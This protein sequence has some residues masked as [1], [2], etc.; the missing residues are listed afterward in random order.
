MKLIRIVIPKNT[1]INEEVSGVF[2]IEVSFD[3]SIPIDWED[4]TNLTNIHFYKDAINE[5]YDYLTYYIILNEYVLTLNWSVLTDANK[6]III[7]EYASPTNLEEQKTFL[8]TNGY[9]NND[10]DEYL[11]D[12]WYAFYIKLLVECNT[13]VGYFIKSLYFYYQKADAEAILSSIS[14]LIIKY[15]TKG[16]IGLNLLGNTTENSLIDFIESKND[17]YENGLNELPYQIKQTVTKSHI[18]SHLKTILFEG[19]FERD[20]DEDGL[21]YH[22]DVRSL[23]SAIDSGQTNQSTDAGI[24][25]FYAYDSIGGQAITKDSEINCNI[26]RD[27]LFNDGDVF[28]KIS[29]VELEITETGKYVFQSFFTTDAKSNIRTTVACELYIDTGNGYNHMHDTTAYLYNRNA[30]NGRTSVNTPFK[31][32][33]ILTGTKLKA[34]VRNEKGNTIETVPNGCSFTIFKMVGGTTTDTAPIIND[35]PANFEI[36]ADES[37]YYHCTAAGN[38]ISWSLANAPIGMVINMTSGE[39]TYLDNLVAGTYNNIEVI[40]TN[41]GGSYSVIFDLVIIE[42]SISQDDLITWFRI[43]DLNNNNDGDVIEMWQPHIGE[44]DLKQSYISYRPIYKEAVYNGVAAL[45]FEDNCHLKLDSS[46]DFTGEFSIFIVAK[47]DTTDGQLFS[48]YGSKN[49]VKLDNNELY[50]TIDKKKS[51]DGKNAYEIDSSTIDE[52]VCL[53]HFS[54]DADSKVFFAYNDDPENV[55]FDNGKAQNKTFI[56]E[57]FMA[58][59]AKPWED[60]D[61]HLCE[62][63]IY[64][65][66]QTGSTKTEIVNYC[67]NK[68]GI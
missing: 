61:G 38:N 52:G 64:N 24:R 66:K 11:F 15:K 44:Q 21:N 29:N 1:F 22:L 60:F 67:I 18:I 43:D 40:A 42:P 62:I 25:C 48:D 17:Y 65:K 45:L 47:A 51:K 59:E 26:F 39:I 32:M 10:A 12:K 36:K 50:I 58:P 57:S 54:R 16:V 35:L 14:N 41:S 63:I 46:I 6:L 49:Y 5:K 30:V 4:I 9:S 23:S 31:I 53:V 20:V 19:D 3:N 13:R 27:V 33:N 8:I 28:N 37:F 2:P 7:D 34:V 55:L 56:I 68:Y